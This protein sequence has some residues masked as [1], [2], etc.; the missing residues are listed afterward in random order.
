MRILLT[1]GSGFIGR[2]LTSYLLEK[3]PDY[4]IINF[5]PRRTGSRQKSIEPFLS[6][7]NYVFV[8][9]LVENEEALNEA[10]ELGVDVVINLAGQT[11]VD[12]SLE[13]PGS[14][15]SAN[16]FGTQ[17]VLD[18]CRK[19]GVKRLVQIS[20]AE[21]YGPVPKGSNVD[22]SA[23]FAPV[24][25]Y[26]ASKAACDLLTQSYHQTF[27]MDTIITRCTNNY[28]PFQ[29]VDKLVPL[30][31]TNA[32]LGK[33]ITLYSDGMQMRDWLHVT[34]HCA[35]IDA[36]IHR[37][38]SGSVYNISGKQTATTR[39]IIEK[40]LQILGR[41]WSLV[42]SI[43]DRP[44]NFDRYALSIEKLTTDTGWEPTYLLENGIIETTNWYQQHS[45]WW[46]KHNEVAIVH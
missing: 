18:M 5:S 32:L 9:G 14:V 29:N 2:N 10:F 4:T 40:V 35:A 33:P 8:E 38:I 46:M 31:I 15:I 11:H 45:D 24:S 22:E 28:G 26:A 25:P 39:E 20:S 30:V 1:G 3:Y 34:D 19:H 7:S 44:G 41:S 43:P 37:G 16:V 42:K 21:V 36:V 27:G 6:R 12:R 17:K 23:A 13:T